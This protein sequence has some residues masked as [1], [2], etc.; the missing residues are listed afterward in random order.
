[1]LKRPPHGSFKDFQAVVSG[2]LLASPRIAQLDGKLQRKRNPATTDEVTLSDVPGLR[3]VVIAF[4]GDTTREALER[5]ASGS[6]K[7]FILL[8]PRWRDGVAFPLC[9]NA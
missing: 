6:V 9:F 5:V 8:A 3:S 1:M 2:L 4:H 7:D